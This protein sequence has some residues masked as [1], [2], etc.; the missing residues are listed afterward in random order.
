MAD[1]W[2]V[3]DKSGSTTP[4]ETTATAPADLRSKVVDLVQ[5]M[6]GFDGSPAAS[7]VAPALTVPGAS[8]AGSTGSLAA[9]GGIV[10][11]LKQFNANGQPVGGAAAIGGVAVQSPNAPTL[12]DPATTGM[13]AGSK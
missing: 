3:A 13:L 5:A 10:D 6:A 12:V 9:V 4:A 7:S 11:V 1:V 8:T 2:F